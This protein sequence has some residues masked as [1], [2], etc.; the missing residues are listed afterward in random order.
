MLKCWNSDP[1]ERP[2]F[3]TLVSSISMFAE[4]ITG[5][6][7]VGNYNSVEANIFNAT[8]DGEDQAKKEHETNI[9]VP[10]NNHSIKINVECHSEDE[11]LP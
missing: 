6:L 1:N 11:S 5:Y 2:L 9:G 8:P 7:D 3:S 10:L 4:K